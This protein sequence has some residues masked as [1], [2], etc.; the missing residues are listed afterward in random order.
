MPDTSVI[1]QN[2]FVGKE[3]FYLSIIIV[4]YTLLLDSSS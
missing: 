2:T 1:A 4:Y 3:Q